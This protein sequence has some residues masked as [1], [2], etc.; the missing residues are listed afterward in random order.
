MPIQVR[1][2]NGQVGNFPDDMPHDQIEAVLQKQFG[3]NQQQ[4]QISEAQEPQSFLNRLPRNIG[5]GA[6]KGL[7]DIGNLP[8]ELAKA[9]QSPMGERKWTLPEGMAEKIHIPE[10]DYSK[11]F[12]LQGDL[13]PSDKAVQMGS[14]FLSP[15]AE[16]KGAQMGLKGLSAGA[17]AIGELPLT[18][19]MAS[20]ALNQSRAQIKNLGLKIDVPTDLLKEAKG[21]VPN[22]TPYKNLFKK[23]SEGD[24]D[25]LFTLQS[26]LGKTSRELMKSSSGAERLHGMQVGDLRSR[27]LNA[28][29]SNISEQGH[30]PIS[31]LITKGQNKYRQNAWLNKAIYPKLKKGAV[32]AAGGIG[33]PLTLKSVFSKSSGDYYGG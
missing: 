14:E 27:L 30:A 17:R 2:P 9:F 6:V 4:N 29:K 8:Y 12:G 7:V 5:A 10:P 32:A 1:L 21:F 22:N 31:E 28:F 13:S 18:R 33:I 16:F 3:F 24:Y 26:D 23:A 11:M 20:K 15:L 19:K 25:S